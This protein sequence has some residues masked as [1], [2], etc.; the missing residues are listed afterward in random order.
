[1]FSLGALV[2]GPAGVD[3]FSFSFCRRVGVGGLGGSRAEASHQGS[4]IKDHGSRIRIKDKDQGLGSRIRIKD[5]GPC[6][7]MNEHLRRDTDVILR[8]SKAPIERSNPR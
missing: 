4:R 1:M 6:P 8:Q 7:A 2:L 3:G 5:H